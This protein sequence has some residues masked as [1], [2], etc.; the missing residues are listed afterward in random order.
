MNHIIVLLSEY[1][2]P[3]QKTLNSSDEKLIT[4]VCKSM[5]S[6]T[7]FGDLGSYEYLRGLETTGKQN[8]ARVI[9]ILSEY[10]LWLKG[11]PL[12]KVTPYGWLDNHP[13]SKF[14]K[15]HQELVSIAPYVITHY[16]EYQ[17][18]EIDSSEFPQDIA[19]Y[20]PRK[21][22]EEEEIE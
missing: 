12:L 1:L 7:F 16:L 15:T 6:V 9:Q 2:K 14:L 5:Y 10:L 20:I 19:K 13:F 11:S 21:T 8:P 3:I 17:K 18:W 22:L 4:E